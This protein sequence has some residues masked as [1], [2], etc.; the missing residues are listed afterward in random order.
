MRTLK[1]QRFTPIAVFAQQLIASFKSPRNRFKYLSLESSRRLR[2]SFLPRVR[3]FFR[4][5]PFSHA[6]RLLTQISRRFAF[7]NQVKI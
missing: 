1:G 6:P 4:G 3:E 2:Y 5:S 7:K